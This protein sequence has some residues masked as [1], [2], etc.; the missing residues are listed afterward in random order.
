MII[1]DRAKFP[2]CIRHF[3]EVKGICV[4][5]CILGQNFYLK[6]TEKW[7]RWG[8]AHCSYDDERGYICLSH[9]FHLKNK[10]TLLHEV[11][12]LLTPLRYSYH[13]QKWRQIVKEI[14]GSYEAFKFS[15]TS[16]SIDYSNAKGK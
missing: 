7:T 10:L 1:T 9:K 11:A 14:G 6:E 12:H 8:H 15:P 13:G 16:W 4:G 5:E 2:K 3:E